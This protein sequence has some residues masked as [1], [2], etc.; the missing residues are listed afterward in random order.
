MD[1]STAI[2]T[3]GSVF[4]QLLPETSTYSP[5]PQKSARTQSPPRGPRTQTRPFAGPCG[6]CSLLQKKLVPSR[7]LF[8]L[9]S[10]VL[11]L[12]VT[13]TCIHTLDSF[14]DRTASSLR[15]LKTISAPALFRSRQVQPVSKPFLRHPEPG[16]GRFPRLVLKSLDRELYHVGLRLRRLSKSIISL[17]EQTVHQQTTHGYGFPWKTPFLPRGTPSPGCVL[18]E[19]KEPAKVPGVWLHLSRWDPPGA[20]PGQIP[21]PHLLLLPPAEIPR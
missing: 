6:G 20:F 15:P 12:F 16:P 17:S 7:D 2:M 5:F 10:G 18:D 9:I 1:Y 11:L 21:P 3:S 14:L 4:T 8:C 19:C 13:P